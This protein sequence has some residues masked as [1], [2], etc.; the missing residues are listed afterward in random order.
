MSEKK[1]LVLI[2]EDY[3]VEQRLLQILIEEIGLEAKVVDS[4]KAALQ[5]LD[6]DVTACI[7]EGDQQAC[8]DAGMD[9]YLSKPF[10]L[11]QFSVIINKWM[12]AQA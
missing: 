11:E 6:K 5:Q 3:L 7:L 9:D 4:G 10:K 2:V 1:P 8:L 12:L